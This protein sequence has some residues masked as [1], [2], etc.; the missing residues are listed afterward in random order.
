MRSILVL[1]S[2]PSAVIRTPGSP[3]PEVFESVVFV[4]RFISCNKKSSFLPSS[5]PW[6][7]QLLEFANVDL[8]P[9]D[10]LRDVA[11]VHQIGDLLS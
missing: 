4:S 2:S 11:S 3:A 1:I 5:P 9:V 8:Q 7:E 6:F 10:F